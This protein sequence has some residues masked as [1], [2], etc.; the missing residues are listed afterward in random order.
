MRKN[1]PPRR[2]EVWLFDCGM[3]AKVRPV[4][5]LSVPF[6]D[7]DRALA[8][9]VLHT[10]TLRGSQFEVKIQV[11][12]LKEGAFVPQSIA[13]LSGRSRYSQTRRA[14]CGAARGSRNGRIQMAR[15]LNAKNGS[16]LHSCRVPR[17]EV[18]VLKGPFWYLKL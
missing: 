8:T 14:E 11:S 13:H 17:T 9:V 16:C 2:G 4:L 1:V 3:V 5:V 7:T 18:A 10:T 6:T 15:S 12:F